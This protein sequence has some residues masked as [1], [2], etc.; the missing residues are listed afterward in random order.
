MRAKRRLTERAKALAVLVVERH[1]EL[2]ASGVRL[3]HPAWREV[4]SRTLKSGEVREKVRFL[5]PRDA[6]ERL[7]D[8]IRRS[9]SVEEV[10]DVMFEAHVAARFADQE[11]IAESKRRRAHIGIS[12]WAYSASPAELL[13][14]ETIDAEAKGVLPGKLP[15]ELEARAKRREKAA[16][17]WSDVQRVF[18][19]Q[20]DD[21]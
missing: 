4:E 3:V 7:V 18:T 8:A 19:A 15:K 16:K 13:V 20:E 11:E 9:R 12:E 21:G 6:T 10:L 14:D 17:Q 5:E 2:A 1:D